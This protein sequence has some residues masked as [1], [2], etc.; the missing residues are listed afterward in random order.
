MIARLT[1]WSFW[2]VAALIGSLVLAAAA[3]PEA[4]PAATTGSISGQVKLPASAPAEW[5]RG[6]YVVTQP[7]PPT[8]GEW[9]TVHVDPSDGT[10]TMAGLA[11]GSY[12]VQFMT[13][14]YRGLDDV[15]YPNVLD[16]YYRAAGS[17]AEFT[18]VRV[19]SGLATDGVDGQ[20]R[21]GEIVTGYLRAPSGVGLQSIYAYS[22]AKQ[23]IVGW[24]ELSPLGW[25]T[26]SKLE[27]GEYLMMFTN[28]SARSQFL[29]RSLADDANDYI[30]TVPRGGLADVNLYA[31]E[32][33]AMI[34][35]TAQA[36]R[37]LGLDDG[38]FAGWVQLYQL[39]D[40]RWIA[41]PGNMGGHPLVRP[42]ETTPYSFRGLPPGIYTVGF[43]PIDPRSGE[44]GPRP[45][46]AVIVP[47]WWRQSSTLSGAEQIAVDNGRS[48]IGIDGRITL[49]DPFVDVSSNSGSTN[50]SVFAPEIAW[51]ARM[52]LANGYPRADGTAAFSPYTSVLRDQMAAFLYRAAG[53]PAYTPPATSPF[54]DVPTNYVFYKEIAWLAS[55]GIST[56]WDIGGGKKE[57]RPFAP[58]LRDQ[59]AAFLYRAAGSPAYTPPA[60]SPFAD[61]P[62]GYV[63]YKEIAWLA[64]TGISAGWDAGGG[65]REYRSF[66]PV[67]RDV[68]AAFLYRYTASR[69]S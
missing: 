12:S 37:I 63:F 55:T 41:L 45:D 9:Q 24:G 29:R 4:A 16:Q 69:R 48:R 6:V 35:G 28:S 32:T 56:G 18:P 1:R 65:R 5:L 23:D 34:S 20:L 27:P 61:V 22:L 13:G 66:T 14:P 51:V 17:G 57:Y 64:G 58:V 15:I 10:Y 11:P 38:S 21:L 33:T 59:M 8:P 25:F 54:A 30:H 40:K 62:R 47:Q 31:R 19:D 53:S 39:I 42:G 44:L 49:R 46:Q 3:S 43:E 7:V 36:P 50:Y 60:T 68:M 2:T 26:L 67:L 52:G